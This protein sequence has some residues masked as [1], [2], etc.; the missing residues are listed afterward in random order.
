MCKPN[1]TRMI[2]P[3]KLEETCGTCANK[4]IDVAASTEKESSAY[5]CIQEL[6]DRCGQIVEKNE[7]TC[8][9]YS[10]KIKDGERPYWGRPEPKD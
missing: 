6:S 8:E 1:G 10:P 9:H 5:V 4:V 7:D 2:P 3:E